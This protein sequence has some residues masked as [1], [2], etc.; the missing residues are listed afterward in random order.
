MN[1][2]NKIAELRLRGEQLPP[3]LILAYEIIKDPDSICPVHAG[4]VRASECPYGNLPGDER[5]GTC[6][7]INISKYGLLRI[8]IRSKQEVDFMVRALRDAS[9]EDIS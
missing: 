1:I 9:H 2:I 7:R 8:G 4:F 3:D 6:F 5:C